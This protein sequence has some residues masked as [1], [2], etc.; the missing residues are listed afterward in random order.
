MKFLPLKS[1]KNLTSCRNRF[2][3]GKTTFVQTLPTEDLRIILA[4]QSANYFWQP[5][6]HDLGTITFDLQTA[7]LPVLDLLIWCFT[8][9][10]L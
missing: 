4:S 5:F 7:Y 8:D 6:I 9:E 1:N 10:A 2:L 3:L